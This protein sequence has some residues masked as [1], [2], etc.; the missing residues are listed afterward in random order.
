MCDVIAQT[1]GHKSSVTTGVLLFIAFQLIAVS[2]RFAC[3]L[4]KTC[5]RQVTTVD[6]SYAA[7]EEINQSNLSTQ[8]FAE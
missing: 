7:A 2:T 4:L 1:S 8:R 5:F 6:T 3:C